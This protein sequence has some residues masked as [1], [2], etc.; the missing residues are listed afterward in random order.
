M[1]HSSS[2][3]A[4]PSSSPSPQESPQNCSYIY[5]DWLINISKCQSSPTLSPHR[6]SMTTAANLTNNVESETELL[7]V[8]S[9]K[10]PPKMA[11][12][13]A[14]Q[15]NNKLNSFGGENNGRIFSNKFPNRRRFSSQRHRR[16][17]SNGDPNEL[18]MLVLKS[19]DLDDCD[20]YW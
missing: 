15:F 20:N 2:S 10:Q 9:L 17:S 11:L 4:P 18:D 14:H 3:P 5:R 7:L 16:S 1:S 8:T 13:L 6:H 19:I 12:S